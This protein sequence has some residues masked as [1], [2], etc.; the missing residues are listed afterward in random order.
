V[1]KYGM[2]CERRGLV[3]DNVRDVMYSG[4]DNVEIEW[5]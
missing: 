4:Y 3:V 2:C 1:H 5:I